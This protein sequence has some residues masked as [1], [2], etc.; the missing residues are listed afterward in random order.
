[1]QSL[2]GDRTRERFGLVAFPAVVS[3]AFLARA[4][5]E[6]GSVRRGSSHGHEAIRIAE[7]LD[8][9]FSL[10]WACLGLAYLYSVRGELSQAARLLERAVAQ[11]R[12][13]NSRTWKI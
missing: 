5:A 4:L 6:R 13:W 7:A 11:C 1:M 8:H 12:E 3:R 2:P 9:P 10:I